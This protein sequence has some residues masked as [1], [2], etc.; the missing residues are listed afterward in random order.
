MSRAPEPDTKDCAANAVCDLCRHGGVGRTPTHLRPE[1][2]FDV[3]D[4]QRDDGHIEQTCPNVNSSHLLWSLLHGCLCDKRLNVGTTTH[5]PAQW[6]MNVSFATHDWFSKQKRPSFPSWRRPPHAWMPVCWR[7]FTVRKV[8]VC[9]TQFVL[10][11]RCVRRDMKQRQH[12]ALFFFFLLQAVSM[13]NRDAHLV[14]RRHFEN[15]TMEH[16]ISVDSHC[17]SQF[18]HVH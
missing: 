16:P 12:L 2:T 6:E 3:D 15:P 5:W 1:T 11:L 17:A 9:A 14:S 8:F 10:I 18:G 4:G 7:C 13:P